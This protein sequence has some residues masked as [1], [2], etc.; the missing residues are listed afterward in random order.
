MTGCLLGYTSGPKPIIDAIAK[1]QSQETSAPSTISQK[2]G[3]AAYTGPMKPVTEMRDDFKKRRD[4]MVTSLQSIQ[5]VECFTPDGAFYL[6]PNR[7]EAHTS[8]LQ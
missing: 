6:F 1:I 7:S 3:I 2:A 4:F 8:E 5:G